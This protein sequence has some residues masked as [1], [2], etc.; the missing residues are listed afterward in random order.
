M[1]INDKEVRE[2]L[3]TDIFSQAGYRISSIECNNTKAWKILRDWVAQTTGPIMLDFK[4]LIV[5]EPWINNTFQAMMAEHEVYLQFWYSAFFVSQLNASLL[6]HGI[7]GTRA[8]NAVKQPAATKSGYRVLAETRGKAMLSAFFVEDKDGQQIAVLDISKTSLKALDSYACIPWIKVAVELYHQEHGTSHIE[9]DFCDMPMNDNVIQSLGQMVS[10]LGKNGISVHIR[11]VGGKLLDNVSSHIKLSENGVITNSDRLRII[12]RSLTENKVG[13]LVKY[14]DN[15]QVDS[16]GRYGLGVPLYCR[17][18]RYVRLVTIRG[19]R[20]VH[21]VCYNGN[22]FYPKE[23]Q[24]FYDVLNNVELKTYDVYV[25]ID[26]LG[27]YDLFMGTKY[28]FCAPIQKSKADS[29]EMIT[30]IDEDGYSAR[31]F[32][33][34]ERIKVVFDDWNVPY[35]K[36]QLQ[37]YIQH[38]QELLSKA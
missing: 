7:T 10:D 31:M 14:L 17:V 16:F 33:I 8:F 5:K 32:T 18:A 22:T 4:D 29:T 38:T 23:H 27:L 37:A 28:H 26:E 6:F 30:D 13:M 3:A 25:G 19:V 11:G 24:R 1:I 34:P 36:E 35:D 20:T 9:I 2:V 21:F 12:K 15:K